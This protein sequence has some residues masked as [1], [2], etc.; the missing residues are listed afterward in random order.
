VT[1]VMVEEVLLDHKVFPDQKVTLAKVEKQVLE[2]LL[3]QKGKRDTKD[4]G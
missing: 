2:G 3:D 1:D 4:R